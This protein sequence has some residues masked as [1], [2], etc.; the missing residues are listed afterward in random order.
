M[1]LNNNAPHSQE[2]LLI[3]ARYPEP[4]QVK[5]RLIPAIGADAAALLYRQMVEH[6][7]Q[8]ARAFQQSRF[9]SIEIWFTGGSTAPMQAWLGQDLIYER[10]PP[11]DLGDRLSYALQTTFNKGNTAAVVIGTD[12]PELNPTILAE[13]FSALHQNDLVLGP[14]KDG[15]YYLIGLQR[16]IRELFVGIS[17]S[18]AEVFE[19]T[20]KI[21][22]NLN[23]IRA[24]LTPLSDVDVPPDLTIWEQ[25][26]CF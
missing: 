15:G 25:R 1:V 22:E 3:F 14:A 8:Q 19:Q 11:G 13:S 23:L 18:T 20:D 2:C 12:C 21:A 16:L 17:W 26:K 24:Y 10:Q 9:I 4:G 7:L 5:T 6:T